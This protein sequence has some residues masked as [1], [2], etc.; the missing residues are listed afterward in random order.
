MYYNGVGVEEDF[1]KAFKYLLKPA[2]QG[3]DD[4]QAYIGIHILLLFK[5]Q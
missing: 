4:A 3:N 1:N 2:T 5:F